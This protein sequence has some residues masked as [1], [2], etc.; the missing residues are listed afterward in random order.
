[1]DMDNPDSKRKAPRRKRD[2]R[3]ILHFD[4]DCFYAQCIE[5]ANPHLKLVP[6]GIK[7]KS[8][9]ATCNYVARS[10][11]VRKLMGIHE[12]KRL[13]PDLVLADGEDLS[14]FRDV[15]KKIYSLL[16]SYSWNGRV[17]RLGLDEVFLD[18]TDVVAYNLE[19]LNHHCLEQS[20]F[21]LSREDPERG[22]GFDASA[23]AGCSWPLDDPDPI[24]KDDD[25]DDDDDDALRLRLRLLLGSHL[26]FYLRQQIEHLG[27]TSACGIATNKLLAKLA[28]DKN[29]PQNQTTLLSSHSPA[30]FLD[31]L[32]L[33]KIP[34][35]GSK[36]ITALKN[37]LKTDNDDNLTVRAARTNPAVSPAA[38][39]RLL[40]GGGERGIGQRIWLLLHGIDTGEVKPARD[41]PR[42]ISIEDTYRGLAS[43]SHIREGLVQITASLLRRMHVDLVEDDSTEHVTTSSV[44]ST[45]SPAPPAATTTGAGKKGRRRW[46]A[47]P[48]TLRLTTRPYYPPSERDRYEYNHGRVSKSVALPR[49]VFDLGAETE[50]IVDRLVEG[51]LLPLFHALNPDSK[52]LSIGLL[53]V[54]VTNM[55]GG[56]DGGGGGD[57][58]AAFRRQ[59]EVE[60]VRA[61]A[62]GCLSDHDHDE[63][64]DGDV[65]E[66]EAE[67]S[68]MEEAEWV[69]EEDEQ[70]G[71]R[72]RL[73]GCVIPFFAAEAHGRWHE[74]G[75]G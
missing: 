29:K 51:T 48:K 60:E 65:V 3:V 63:E 52:R 45:S 41:V 27:Y 50:V 35:I 40:A 23:V 73:C 32:P 61:V 34:G 5:N 33:S 42:Q 15:S 67:E 6:L 9:L 49:F 71:M 10:H 38:L 72:C 19:L 62:Y 75:E 21:C 16:K 43:L 13:C 69:E 12:A 54:C 47:Q 64:E 20:W 53:N 8:I 11:G 1:M 70:D 25:D 68:D 57:I 74:V 55:D 46:T 31:P 30:S 24:S 14:P 56:N 22:F 7:Q 18:V 37:L 4:L 2:I 66:E 36:T 39:E 44:S 28:G 59:K 26:A 17:E 58:V